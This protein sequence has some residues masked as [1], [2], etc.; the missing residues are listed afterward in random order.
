VVAKPHLR[1]ELVPFFDSGHSWSPERRDVG[2]QTLLSMGIGTRM[3]VTNWGRFEFYW[4]KRFDP[5][6]RAGRRDAQDDGIHFQ[7]SM[8]WP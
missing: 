7:L 5:V 3:F 6:P 4:A 1:V 8:D 2:E